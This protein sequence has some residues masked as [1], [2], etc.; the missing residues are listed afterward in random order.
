MLK[1]SG[2][3]REGPLAH[4]LSVQAIVLNVAGGTRGH[5]RGSKNTF[6]EV[7]T[8]GRFQAGLGWANHHGHTRR[9][10]HQRGV[11]L[12]G[13]ALRPWAAPEMGPGPGWSRARGGEEGAHGVTIL[14][15]LC[16]LLPP[17]SGQRIST[18]SLEILA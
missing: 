7:W 9:T 4:R 1:D 17:P 5:W 6:W 8:R 14:R 10:V 2:W 15:S 13:G 16:S 3:K 18:A 11:C 12:P